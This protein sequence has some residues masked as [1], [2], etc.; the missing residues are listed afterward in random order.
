ME[1]VVST[2]H[3]AFEHSAVFVR[4]VRTG[5]RS[6]VTQTGQVIPVRPGAGVRMAPACGLAR[7]TPFTGLLSDR[8]K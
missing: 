2:Q 4:G 8:D 1:T 3:A 7:S 6:G 5:G